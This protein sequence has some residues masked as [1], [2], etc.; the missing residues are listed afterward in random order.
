VISA[1]GLTRTFRSRTGPVEAVRG[2]DFEVGSG[3]I[4]GIL[5]P[6]GAGK[7]TTVR[8]LSTLL[9]PTTGSATVDGLDVVTDRDRVRSRIGLVSQAGGTGAEHRVVNELCTQ[10]RLYGLSRAEAEH[11]V[12]ALAADFE[13]TDLLPRSV[14][15]LSGGQRRRVD[16]L[17]GL[18]HRPRVLFLDEPTAGLDP[19]VRADVWNHLRDL[20]KNYG[21][22]MLLTT[23]YLD[24]ADQLCDRVLVIDGGKVVASGTPEALKN[25]V[26]GDLVVL[27]TSHPGDAAGVVSRMFPSV[28]VDTR[29][30]VVQFHL[31]G[32]QAMMPELF[33]GL[34]AAHVH[35]ASIAVTRPSLDDVFLSLTG[36]S[37]DPSRLPI[38]EP[39]EERVRDE[40]P[41]GQPHHS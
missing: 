10:A 7:T 22:T 21:L 16:I 29:P 27:A 24:E 23:H 5:G 20:R 12:D 30:G 40:N 13:L 6:N 39:I 3:E 41:A 15:T 4:V 33:R 8:M 28:D 26:G 1:H 31:P 32:A 37:L 14:R 9:T 18:L 34:D 2:V 17:M 35:L 36:H 38:A 25:A 11:R 19:H